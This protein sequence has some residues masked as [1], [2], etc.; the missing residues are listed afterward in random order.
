MSKQKKVDVYNTCPECGSVEVLVYEQTAWKLLANGDF[1]HYHQ[2]VK[3]Y[4]SDADVSCQDCDWR[5]IRSD[6]VEWKDE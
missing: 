1:E 6:L 5:G 4:D 2:S 3:L